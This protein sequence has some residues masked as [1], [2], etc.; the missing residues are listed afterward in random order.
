MFGTSLS[1]A[2]RSANQYRMSLFLFI[3]HILHFF[4]NHLSPTEALMDGKSPAKHSPVRK[5]VLL[6]LFCLAAFLDAFNNNSLYSALPSLVLSLSI[7]ES[8]TTWVM[9]AFQLT[10][11]S[12]LLIVSTRSLHCHLAVADLFC[13]L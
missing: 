12:F 8:E 13:S 2:L 4:P 6:M 1:G 11:A 10:F 9:S 5:N 3:D 7:T